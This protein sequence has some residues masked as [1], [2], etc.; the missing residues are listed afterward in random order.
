MNSYVLTGSKSFLTLSRSHR[1]MLKVFVGTTWPEKIGQRPEQEQNFIECSCWQADVIVD[2]YGKL[3]FRICKIV[4]S[5]FV[6]T[7]W[8]SVCRKG[9]GRSPFSSTRCE[10]F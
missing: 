9:L 4:I 5:S 10:T 8:A 7:V 1:S 2:D 6:N 3:D